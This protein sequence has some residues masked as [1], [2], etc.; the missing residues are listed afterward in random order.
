MLKSAR[1]S[2]KTKYVFLFLLLASILSASLTLLSPAY[3]VRYISPF[4]CFSC[5]AAAVC[6]FLFCLLPELRQY[7][8][9]VRRL[10]EEIFSDEHTS[11]SSLNISDTIQLLDMYE[12]IRM[13][14]Y[15]K[16]LT[17][18]TGQ[19]AVLQSQ[20][21]PH[22]LYNTLDSIRGQAL[23]Y[24]LQ[25]IADMTEALSSFFRYNVSNGP[26]IVPLRDE[27]RNIQAYF[28]IQQ[29]RF[30]NRFSLRIDSEDAQALD[31]Y[32]P[33]LTLQPL[34]ENCIFHGLEKISDHGIVTIRILL[35]QKRLL[36]TVSDNGAGISAET[37]HSIQKGLT[38]GDTPRHSSSG[39]ALFNV[40]ER[41]R[42]AFGPM[43]GLTL[44]SQPDI[45]TEAEI[46]LPRIDKLEELDHHL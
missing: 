40:N 6:L 28:Q 11:L 17:K 19:L 36:I 27:I 20:I 35:T 14:Q 25:E 4:L 29:Y 9:L 31:C 13:N 12:K 15:E 21:N 18:K 32:L 22:F 30:E 3:S 38:D 1:K 44:S 33:K 37:L 10:K 39:I 26:N 43:Y 42:L 23:E 41:I 7:E 46:I 5:A 34:V 45:G 16:N 8:K 24:H 2:A